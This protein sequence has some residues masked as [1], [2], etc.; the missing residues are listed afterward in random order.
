MPGR[1]ECL[2]CSKPFA[3][4]KQWQLYCSNRCKVRHWRE[5]KSYCF[6]CGEWQPSDRHHLYPIES[7]GGPRTYANQETIWVCKTCN[8]ELADRNFETVDDQFCW[9]IA[10]YERSKH[11]KMPEW[12]PPEVDEL[13]ARLR[14]HVKKGMRMY[15]LVSD[16]LAYLK[17]HRAMAALKEIG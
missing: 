1:R 8:G 9:L 16:K 7:R 13:G 5:V 11:L 15:H 3:I 4:S 17:I 12:T 14:Q 2:Y 10:F 6:F